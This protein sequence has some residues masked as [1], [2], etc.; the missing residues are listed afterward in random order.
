MPFGE[1]LQTWTMG[2]ITV[3]WRVVELRGYIF[4]ITMLFL[5]VIIIQKVM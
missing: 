3:V 2:W 4:E 1:P 5:S